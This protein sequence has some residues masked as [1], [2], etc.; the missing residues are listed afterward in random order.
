MGGMEERVELLDG[1][2]V[3]LRLLRREDLEKLYEFFLHNIKE[4]DLL[5]FKDNVRDYYLVKS[6][7]EN[8]DISKVV[9]VV[10]E[11]PSGKIIG[12][13]TL[14]T[15]SHG[16]AKDVGKIRVSICA[17]CRGK[18]LGKAIVS[19][20]LEIAKSRDMRAVMAEVVSPQEVALN[21]LKRAGFEEQV[22]IKEIARDHKFR[23]LDLHIFVK[24][25]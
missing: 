10:A 18:G 17:W 24:Y 1:S 15:R 4:E 9:P 6:W 3:T 11:T 16:W 22:V 23:P 12:V 20:L 7:C 14:H 5:L 13:G 8:I 2:E 19:K 21:T 25:L